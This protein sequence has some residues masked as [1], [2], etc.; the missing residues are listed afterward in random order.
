MFV[1][2]MDYALFLQTLLT[3]TKPDVA[4]SL[5]SLEFRR[6]SWEIPM[7]TSWNFTPKIRKYDKSDLPR[8][9]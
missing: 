6:I 7:W 5:K 2:S 3:G 4:K 8:Y 1:K 9:L